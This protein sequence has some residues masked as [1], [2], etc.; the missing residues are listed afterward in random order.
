MKSNQIPIRLQRDGLSNALVNISFNTVYQY[1]YI[2]GK[3][4][5]TL[6]Q[7]EVFPACFSIYCVSVQK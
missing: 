1:S 7:R 3:V 2:V 6:S 5:E 4:V